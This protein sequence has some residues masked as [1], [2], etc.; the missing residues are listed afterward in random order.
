MS[1]GQWIL[2]ALAVATLGV[3]AFYALAMVLYAMQGIVK[4]AE[5]VLGRFYR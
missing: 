4:G 2:A 5:K 1:I 3:F